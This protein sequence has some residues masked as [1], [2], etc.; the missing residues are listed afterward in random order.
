MRNGKS[1]RG[2]MVGLKYINDEGEGFKVAVVVSKKVSNSAVIRNRIRRRIYAA[3]R[4]SKNEINSGFSGVF[5]GFDENLKD[6]SFEKIDAEIR[7][8]LQKAK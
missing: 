5:T 2:R 7:V 8:L 3:V 1:L 6:M 4:N